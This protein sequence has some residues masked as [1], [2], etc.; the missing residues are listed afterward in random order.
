[1][2]PNLHVFSFKVSSK[3]KSKSFCWAQNLIFN[4]LSTLKLSAFVL[5][6]NLEGQFNAALSHTWT[7][8]QRSLLTHIFVLEK[9]KK[10]DIFLQRNSHTH[11]FVIYRHFR[12]STKNCRFRFFLWIAY[13]AF[14]YAVAVNRGKISHSQLSTHTHFSTQS[15]SI[16]EKSKQF[17]LTLR[18]LSTKKKK[19]K[20]LRGLPTLPMD[21]YWIHGYR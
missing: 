16:E 21:K 10:K 17:S 3:I 19:E 6:L 7:T 18:I 11:I 8:F 20:S 9:K 1:M 14:F 5:Q 2:F 4:L 13:Y 12:Q 15:P